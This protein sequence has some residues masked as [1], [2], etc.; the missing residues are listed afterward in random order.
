MLRQGLGWGTSREY[1]VKTKDGS[2]SLQ[3]GTS[4]T[5]IYIN[6]YIYRERERGCNLFSLIGRG[7]KRNIIKVEGPRGYR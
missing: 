4:Y 6:I 7:G 2:P 5:Q 3:K 1:A